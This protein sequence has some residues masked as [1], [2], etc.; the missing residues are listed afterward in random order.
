LKWGR[1]WIVVVVVR[2]EEGVGGDGILYAEVVDCLGDFV[3][4]QD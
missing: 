4:R 1:W 2:G 3:S